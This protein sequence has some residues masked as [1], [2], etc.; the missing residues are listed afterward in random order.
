M[1][2]G[3][4]GFLRS[5]KNRFCGTIGY[6]EGICL[7]NITESLF[8]YVYLKTGKL[9]YYIYSLSKCSHLKTL[10]MNPDPTSVKYQGYS[11]QLM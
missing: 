11:Y 10:I 5:A 4:Y 6:K 8:C 1:S 2:I 9:A 7:C 3:L